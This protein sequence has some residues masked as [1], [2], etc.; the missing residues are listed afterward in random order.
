MTVRRRIFLLAGA[1]AAA[2]ACTAAILVARSTSAVEQ[3]VAA[4]T[5]A[6]ASGNG[7]FAAHPGKRDLP[8]R[9]AESLLGSGSDLSFRAVAGQA[10][11]ALAVPLT[12][13]SSP[14]RRADAELA[15][16]AF[17]ASGVRAHRSLATNLLGELVFDDAYTDTAN[18]EQHVQTAVRLF[19]S[20]IELDPGN[21]AAKSNLEMALTASVQ[22]QPGTSAGGVGSNGAAHAAA[23]AGY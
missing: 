8:F 11:S 7:G 23:G 18:L 14:Q 5:A 10:E 19:Q 3:R 17:V 15:L 16:G 6:L 9:I 13:R 22:G 20:A 2:L 4:T 12:D 1:A 21:D